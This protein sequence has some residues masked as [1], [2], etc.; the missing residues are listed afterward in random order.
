MNKFVIPGIL[1]TLFLS[2]YLQDSWP[3]VC[4]ILLFFIGLYMLVMILNLLAIRKDES[5]WKPIHKLATPFSNFENIVKNVAGDTCIVEEHTIKTPDGVLLKCHRVRLNEKN[6]KD[7]MDDQFVGKV[8]VAHHSFC[9]CS[10]I[11]YKSFGYFFVMRGFDVWFTNARGNR[12]SLY[13]ENPNIPYKEFFD[14]TFDDMV[15]D[16]KTVYDYVIE[17]TSET[18]ITYISY[19]IGGEIFSCSHSDPK[20]LEFYKEHTKEAILFAPL[21]YPSMQKEHCSVSVTTK[22]I[23]EF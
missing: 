4:L 19:S 21:L 22:S 11:M 9:N 3:T 1:F 8:V 7:L 6:A 15:D 2:M 16:L 18:K 13:H 23:N 20:N 10:E 14:F 12:Y 5:A 17:K